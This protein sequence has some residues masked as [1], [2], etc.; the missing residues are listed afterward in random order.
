MV[1][2]CSECG[3]KLEDDVR[4][5]PECGE[6]A[7]PAKEIKKI[8]TK[9]K[10]KTKKKK[11]TVKFNLPKLSLKKVPKPVI[12]GIALLCIAIIAV[13][14][15][16][17]IS[18]FDTTGSVVKVEQQEKVG[19]RVFSV[20]VENTCDAEATCYLT[21]GG[22][23]YME[24]GNDEGYFTVPSEESITLDI[25]EDIL[26]LTKANYDITL[27]AEIEWFQEGTAFD[28]T[29]SAEFSIYQADEEFF[30]EST[31]AR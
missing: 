12:V 18:P 27:F 9:S 14:G 31:G 21:V 28:V 5:C 24:V 25:V 6:K 11:T 10:A 22:L 7:P 23:K 3:N 26:F 17:V 15:V 30:I 13:A 4:F 8:E 19:G 2:N 16:V 1:E 29:E 20:A